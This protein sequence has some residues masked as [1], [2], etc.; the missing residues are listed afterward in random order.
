MTRG[1]QFSGN[2]GEGCPGIGGIERRK[3]TTEKVH[4]KYTTRVE[5]RES[6][7][8]HQNAQQCITHARYSRKR[9]EAE[10]N[11]TRI[12]VT[13]LTPKPGVAGSSLATPASQIQLLANIF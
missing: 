9:N 3:N 4:R 8:T 1:G 6:E 10:E 12:N 2:A 7:T 5:T 13:H 11:E